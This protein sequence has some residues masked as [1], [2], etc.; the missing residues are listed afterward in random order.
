[1]FP[2][3]AVIA[4]RVIQFVQDTMSCFMSVRDI[5]HTRAQRDAYWHIG[6]LEGST[7]GREDGQ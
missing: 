2:F 3:G 6:F 7:G 4:A 1:M 5:T